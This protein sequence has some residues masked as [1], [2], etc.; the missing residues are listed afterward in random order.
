MSDPGFDPRREFWLSCRRRQGPQFAK[1]NAQGRCSSRATRPGRKVPEVN[2]PDLRE[3]SAY[4]WRIIYHLRNDSVFIVT[5]IY[6]RR[7]PGAQ[8]FLPDDEPARD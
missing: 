7:H 3:I 4:P 5:L 1:K 2:D 6:K 8:D